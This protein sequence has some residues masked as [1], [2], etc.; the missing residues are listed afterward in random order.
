MTEWRLFPLADFGV[1]MQCVTLLT[2]YLIVRYWHRFKSK[3]EN[4]V[5]IISLWKGM[6]SL[7]E[8]INIEAQNENATSFSPRCS[9]CYGTICNEND[10]SKIAR[11]KYYSFRG[12]VPLFSFSSCKYQDYCPLVII[13]KDKF[14]FSINLLVLSTLHY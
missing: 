12:I 10:N 11:K 6:I 2:Q 9:P 4:Y 3:L 8:F 5:K 7:P 14:A 1:K 13:Y